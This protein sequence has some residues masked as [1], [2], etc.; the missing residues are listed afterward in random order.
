MAF[1]D[2]SAFHIAALTPKTYPNRKAN[3][4]KLDDIKAKFAAL[5]KRYKIILAG[6][7]V[8]IIL[9]TAANAQQNCGPLEKVTDTLGNKYG[10]APIAQGQANGAILQ[11]WANS[12]T[13]SWTIVAVLP[14]G[15]ACLVADGREFRA[16]EPEPNV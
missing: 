7:V 14:N 3:A 5:P 6:V 10:E 9:A 15:A 1:P 11:M 13:G 12:V 16:L 8:F 2:V 4:M